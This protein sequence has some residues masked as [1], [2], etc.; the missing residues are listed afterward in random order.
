MSWRNVHTKPFGRTRQDA[1]ALL[2]A[3]HIP[4]LVL[5][6]ITCFAV[7]FTFF[8]VDTLHSLHW[9][10]EHAMLTEDSLRLRLALPFYLLFGDTL[11]GLLF[12]SFFRSMLTSA[13][14]VP[15]DPWRHVPRYDAVA[16]QKVR[17][18]WTRQQQWLAWNRHQQATW[19]YQCHMRL[20]MHKAADIYA[21]VVDLPPPVE[22]VPAAADVA[23]MDI[24]GR[25]TPNEAAKLPPYPCSRSTGLSSS[26]SAI[27][28]CDS[29]SSSVSSS[30]S[31]SGEA[32][33]DSENSS[34]EAYHPPQ[35]MEVG[36]NHGRQVLHVAHKPRR[37]SAAKASAS[38]ASQPPKRSRPLCSA[39][40]F[41]VHEWEADGSL[42]YCR[43]CAQFKPDRCHHCR[44]C[45]RCTSLMDHHCFYLN[46][47]IGRRNYKFFFLTFAY[48]SACGWL[49][50]L[51]FFHVFFERG[52]VLRGLRKLRSFP[53]YFS[54]SY[55][56]FFVLMEQ[57]RSAMR[58][59][60]WWLLV[61]LGMLLVNML[62]FPLWI[63]HIGLLW[64][65]MTTLEGMRQES[66][67]A[68]L[69]K[70][71]IQRYGRCAPQ[72]SCICAVV[73]EVREWVRRFI[74]QG[75]SVP[76]SEEDSDDTGMLER[77]APVGVAGGRRWDAFHGGL[78]YAHGPS[79][80]EKRGELHGGASA[81]LGE[82]GN[83]R[84]AV[85]LSERRSWHWRLLFGQPQHG[86]WH[87]LLP[88]PP[89]GTGEQPGE[90]ETALRDS[91]VL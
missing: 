23:A 14:Y 21:Q 28:S 89:R 54:G 79:L 91:K 65:G 15:S 83:Q 71:N 9:L 41:T 39:N 49:C 53:P 76:Q 61:P 44:Y 26:R 2:R 48:G 31:D 18:E 20:L 59:S 42:R 46:N 30:G 82:P 62:V 80:A 43:V 3:Y 6:M 55:G 29:V 57:S 56:D 45:D 33:S 1:V 81:S 37:A 90:V 85:S 50:S 16:Q 75:Y 84:N 73:H 36:Y 19:Q 34:E 47:C 38:A 66:V 58:C 17:E 72:T 27:S 11:F 4:I 40:P 32:G 77:E 67:D 25:R 5:A 35:Q 86:W 60:T 70:L 13:G 64:R 78:D 88:L 8:L 52:R 51:A 12:W 24:T 22:A 69:R 7:G 10:R 68:F 63:H 87:H 74:C